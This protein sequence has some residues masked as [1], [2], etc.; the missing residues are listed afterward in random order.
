MNSTLLSLN[1]NL[2]SFEIGLPFPCFDIILQSLIHLKL[3]SITFFSIRTWSIITDTSFI[4]IASL[5]KSPSTIEEVILY[6]N[7]YNDIDDIINSAEHNPNINTV[8]LCDNL[9]NYM[10]TNKYDKVQVSACKEVLKQ[11]F[12]L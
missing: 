2:K 12:R 3:T 11:S 4:A 6:F 1:N 5:L 9:A 7:T 8:K 10:Y